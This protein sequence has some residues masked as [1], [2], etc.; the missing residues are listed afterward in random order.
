MA[1]RHRLD[2]LYQRL[3]AERGPDALRQL[4][5]VLAGMPS[6][7][8]D[9]YLDTLATA[10]LGPPQ[11]RAERSDRGG[12]H[13]LPERIYSLTCECGATFTAAR[14]DARYCSPTCRQRAYRRRKG[15]EQP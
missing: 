5:D 14:W 15:G 2:R 8:A 10:W 4:D 1:S 3:S 13:A 6:D 9:S 11:P 12:F 7:T